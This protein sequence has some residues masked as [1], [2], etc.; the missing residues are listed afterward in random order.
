MCGQ[1]TEE[2]Q[3]RD[4]KDGFSKKT[5]DLEDEV[6]TEKRGDI[7]LQRPWAEAGTGIVALE[8]GRLR[9]SL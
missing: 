2:D 1:E 6:E 4:S 7:A 8:V 9:L 5:C 3:V